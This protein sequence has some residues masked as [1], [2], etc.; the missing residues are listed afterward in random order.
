MDGR[1]IPEE[2]DGKFF[3]GDMILTTK[4]RRPLEERGFKQYPENPLLDFWPPAPQSNEP[5]PVVPY[6]FDSSI[7]PV[8]IN[9]I[10]DCIAHWEANTCIT[11][12]ETTNFNQPRIIFI[13]AEFS[14]GYFGRVNSNNGQE[15]KIGPS[16]N[17]T[18]KTYTSILDS[19]CSYVS[20][21]YGPSVIIVFDGYTNQPSTKDGTH[22]RRNKTV[23][24]NVSFTSAMPLKMK[25]QEFL[26]NND[27]K[28][29]FINMLSECLERTGFQVHNA[30]GD[31]DV[32]IAQTAVMAAKK[33][34]TV[35]VGDDTDLLILLLHLYQCGELYF[36]SEPR[37]SSSSS[38]HKYLNIGRAC[39]ILA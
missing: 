35:L 4:Q 1:P 25:K 24:R 32:L 28:Q 5:Y 20:R 30:D 34:R 8:C 27:N 2:V 37:K 7:E 23:G 31:A 22:T 36:M 16:C 26:S 11:F 15:I 21:H 33:H 13:M 6:V 12:Q 18:G 29:R 38:S 17:K 19:Y 39:G 3:D 9:V 14:G 10:K